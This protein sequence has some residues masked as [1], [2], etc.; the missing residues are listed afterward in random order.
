MATE[1]KPRAQLERLLEDFSSGVLVTHAGDGSLHGRPLAV[2]GHDADGELWF[3]TA[4]ES[5]KVQEL[6]QDERSLVTLQS[7]AKDVVLSGMARV[8]RD[9]AKAQGLWK[10][11]FR[12]WFPKGVDDP[13][14]VLIRFV[15]EV[16][17]YWDRSGAKGLRHG[18]QA[19]KAY[20]TGERAPEPTGDAHGSVRLS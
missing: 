12:V 3:M 6:H 10:E 7:G 4:V 1:S 14:L 13:S 20:L 8:V 5:P 19:A 9:R 2:A 16:A 15:P 11:S 17:E 18:I